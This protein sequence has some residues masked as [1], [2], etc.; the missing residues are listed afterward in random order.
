VTTPTLRGSRP[1]GPA[2]PVTV[3]IAHDLSLRRS[4]LPDAAIRDL[5]AALS[6]PNPEYAKRE[7]VGRK[8]I[9]LVRDE[10]GKVIASRPVPRD[11]C[12][13]VDSGGYLRVP[14]GA[15]GTL[16][17]TL[18]KHGRRIDLRSEVVWTGDAPLPADAIPGGDRPYQ[19][20]AE[21]RLLGLWP[22]CPGVQGGIVLPC[23][24][25]KTWVGVRALLRSRQS[26]LVLVHTVD[27]FEQ[28]VGAIL[29]ASGRMP[30][31]VRGEKDLAPL[32][33]GEIA[34][35][36]VQGLRKAGDRALPLLQSAGALVC[37]EAHHLPAD[38]FFEVV[39]RCPARYRW[40]LSA[41]PERED[42]LGFVLPW[43]MGPIL[44]RRTSGELARDG[45]LVLPRVIPVR[46]LWNPDPWKHYSG[47]ASGREPTLDWD[48]TSIGIAEDDARNALVVRL[49]RAAAEGGR[50]VLV[51]VQRVEHA[52]ALASRIASC[53]IAAAP[54]HGEVARGARRERLAALR[55]GS[56][57]VAV[58]TSLADEGLD[59][60]RLG[61][62]I[63]AAPQKTWGRSQQRVGR[64]TRPH[65]DKGAGIAIDLVDGGPLGSQ[66]R[67]R[68]RAYEEALGYAPEP[69][70]GVDA[71]EA[72]LSGA[73]AR[74]VAAF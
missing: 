32:A 61:C 21:D 19:T 6:R 9:D 10:D 45:Y 63:S 62:L 50:T 42:G 51:L 25:G 29:R 22:G 71:L 11:L 49:A 48:L 1:T 16:R 24:G 53:G 2:I 70:A 56:L 37:D 20:E 17:A 34:V 15:I 3:R 58:A 33:P 30:R 31:A 67:R 39:S 52:E 65:G 35:A 4:D 54:I 60:P 55:D 73:A 43:T 23:G 57:Q 26:G 59:V 69:F 8:P 28:W 18:I 36:M 47:H 72:V 40:W 74:Q 27:L 38:T 46:T 7:R 64:L 14:R 44:L 66:W 5:Q 41:T 12:F 13:L 68:A